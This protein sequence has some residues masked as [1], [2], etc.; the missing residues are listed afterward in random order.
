MQPYFLPYLGYFQL[1]SSVE[2]FVIYDDIEYTKK[3]WI[4]RN[5][6]LL[7]GAATT[8]TVPLRKDSDF[9]TVRERE[10]SAEYDRDALLARIR[11]AYLRAPEFDSTFP[12]IREVVGIPE[13]NLFRYIHSGL[14]ALLDHLAIP[15]EMIVSSTIPIEQGLRGQDKVL[16]ICAALGADSYVNAIGG[17]ELY[18]PSAFAKAGVE[19]AFI[20]SLPF[21]YPQ[22][23]APFVPSLSILDVLMFNDLDSVQVGVHSGYRL[24]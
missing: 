12:L 15:T 20:E 22:F 21:E 8:I 19:L 18:D 16:A 11:G 10:I 23:G 3:G 2:R 5:R 1:V 17:R 7:N 9:L 6:I 4:N 14:L 24:I 13:S